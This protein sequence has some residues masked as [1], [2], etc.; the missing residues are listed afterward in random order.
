MNTEVAEPGVEARHRNDR[1]SHESVESEIGRFIKGAPAVPT[2]PDIRALPHID[3]P[4]RAKLHFLSAASEGEARILTHRC[5]QVG[6]S[7]LQVNLIDVGPR[8]QAGRCHL[9]V[10][11]LDECSK[12]V[13]DM[14]VTFEQQAMQIV[15]RGPPG[16]Q[17]E[18]RGVEVLDALGPRRRN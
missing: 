12:A 4:A 17:A 14:Q 9:V 16:R 10:A 6:K 1:L 5:L 8:R 7:L 11:E 3:Q 15:G 2:L 18:E 13:A